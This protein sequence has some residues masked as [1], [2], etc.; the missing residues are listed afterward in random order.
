MA[1]KIHLTRKGRRKSPAYRVVVAD[2]RS[3][4]DGR[5]V[6]QVGYYQPLRAGDHADRVNLNLERIQYWLSVGAK[7][8]DRVSVLYGGAISSGSGA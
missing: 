2:T 6:E 7:M 1:V 3:P 8:S 5:F 4:R